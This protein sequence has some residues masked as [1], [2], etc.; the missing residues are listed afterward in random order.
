MQSLNESECLMFCNVSSVAADKI[1]ICMA[2]ESAHTID[3][4][5]S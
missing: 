4:K 5:S 1:H 3:Q 2:A